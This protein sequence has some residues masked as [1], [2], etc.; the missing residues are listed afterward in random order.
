MILEMNPDYPQPRKVDRVIDTLSRGGLIAY[1]TDSVYGIGCDV[2]NKQAVERLSRL[3]AELKGAPE[4]APLAFI[5]RD[6]SNI[7][8]YATI[9]DY[10][11]RT[12]RRLLPG[13]YTFILEASRQVPKVMRKKRKTVGIRVPDAQIPL[14]IVS[15]LGNPITTTSAQ[16]STGE[17]IADPWTLES[18]YGHM[19]DLVID[20]GYLFPEPTTII[21]FT[22]GLPHLI[23]E[24]KGPIDDIEFFEPL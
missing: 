1:P 18:E 12:M 13:A 5:C 4:H 22:S 3:V 6:L 24:G 11:Y 9:S 14:E 23:R 7:A 8:E 2:F 16:L 19:I 21:D 20:G 10:A 15:R 17:L